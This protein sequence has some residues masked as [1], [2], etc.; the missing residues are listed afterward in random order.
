MGK[1]NPIKG[2]IVGPVNVDYIMQ[3]LCDIMTRKSGGEVEYS[4]TLTPKNRKEENN[5][6]SDS[7]Y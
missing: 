5:G 1:A 3:V 2:R 4:Y 6:N 7:T